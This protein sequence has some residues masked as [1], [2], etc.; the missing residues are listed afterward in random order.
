VHSIVFF[1]ETSCTRLYLMK[2]VRYKIAEK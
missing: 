1:V 2:N